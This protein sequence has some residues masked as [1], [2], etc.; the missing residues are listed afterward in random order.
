MIQGVRIKD[1]QPILNPQGGI[2]HMVRADEK[3]LFTQFG[4]VYLSITNP[5]VVKGWHR[6]VDM[7]NIHSC[8]VGTLKLVLFDGRE[9]SPTFGEIVEVVYGEGQH[10]VVRIPPGVTYGWK[11]IGDKPAILANCASHVHDPSKSVKIDLSSGEIPY[12]W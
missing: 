11:N 5:G 3:E 9:N 4:E 8:I 10:K 12:G 6:H 7:T 1:V 2:L